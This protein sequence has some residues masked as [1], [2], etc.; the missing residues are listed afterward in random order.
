MIASLYHVAVVIIITLDCGIDTFNKQAF[1]C[2][3]QF[4]C[5]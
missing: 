5:I 1:F 3:C 2:S 4:T